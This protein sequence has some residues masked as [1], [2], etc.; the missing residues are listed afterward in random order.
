MREVL[1]VPSNEIRVTPDRR[2]EGPGTQWSQSVE[3]SW[4]AFVKVLSS[5]ECTNVLLVDQFA[6]SRS[7]L[8]AFLSEP[9]G[10]HVIAE[11]EDPGEALEAFVRSKPDLVVLS[12]ATE[13]EEIRQSGLA[14]L[15]SIRSEA[16]LVP[17]ITVVNDGSME[18]LAMAAR[19]GVQGVISRGASELMF[20][21]C[22]R[23]VVGGDCALGSLI[24]CGVLS[25]F[26]DLDAREVEGV[27]GGLPLTAR[28]GDVLAEMALGLH[29]REIAIHLGL[30]TAT[31][32]TH[33][34]QICRKMG[35]R[36]RAQVMLMTVTSQ[37]STHR[38]RSIQARRLRLTG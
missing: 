34:R 22:V 21:E 3:G 30:A 37:P 35:A 4:V 12:L 1:E 9:S 5:S 15:K 19:V 33:V 6:L 27:S 29:N 28:E 17:I 10:F 23:T 18:A 31:V 32:K 36:D 2:G 38:P 16:P 8:R 24:S 14:A 7:G 13:P 26:H 20:M 25:Y 11:L